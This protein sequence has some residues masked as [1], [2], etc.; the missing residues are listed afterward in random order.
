MN[1][2]ALKTK[3]EDIRHLMADGKMDKAVEE[4]RALNA[5]I[6]DSETKNEIIAISANYNEL[7]R[8]IRNQIIGMS[9]ISLKRNRLMNQMLD[10]LTSMEQGVKSVLPITSPS[11]GTLSATS[12]PKKQRNPLIWTL[13]ILL[14]LGIA[15]GA[16]MIYQ[17]SNDKPASQTPTSPTEAVEPTSPPSS[18]CDEL[19]AEAKDLINQEELGK[20][21]V[22]MRR[23][24]RTCP[25]HK[26]LPA[27]IEQL[28][29][30]QAD[31]NEAT[32][33]TEPKEIKQFFLRFNDAYLIH[34]FENNRKITQLI[35][36]DRVLA[37]EDAL[38]VKQLKDFLFQVKP[39][40]L[41]TYF[42]QVNTSRS[43]VELIRGANFGSIPSANATRS[44]ENEIEV[45]AKPNG[46]KPSQF[47]IAFK[48]FYLVY[49]PTSANTPQVTASKKVLQYGDEWEVK[50]IDN[51]TYHLKHKTWNNGFWKVD[52]TNKRVESFR[53]V[54][55]FGQAN[56]N[57]NELVRAIVEVK[58]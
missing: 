4:L 49:A 27:L 23:L 37:R 51:A 32:A 55:D 36:S 21:N 26:L 47:K 12:T 7:E 39:K 19:I 29:Q 15:I 28:K 33:D 56:A 10:L 54:A 45:S 25:D 53:S 30:K 31:Q 14:L 6:K 34:S 24:S 40:R 57:S 38:D 50:K 8:D 3:I 16:F 9:D 1:N 58:Y 5:M 13:P 20:A 35:A 2:Q 17:M 18:A 42:W 43:S 11:V 22:V 52:V 44:T 48:D 46:N 41:N